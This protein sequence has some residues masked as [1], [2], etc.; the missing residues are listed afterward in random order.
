[1]NRSS[2][3]RAE[4]EA[5]LRL[6]GDHR[7]AG[8]SELPEHHERALA[9]QGKHLVEFRSDGEHPYQSVAGYLLGDTMLVDDLDSA[10]EMFQS[11]RIVA[12]VKMA[13]ADLTQSHGLVHAI[14]AGAKMVEE[15]LED[16]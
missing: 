13:Q 7:R 6:V 15:L 8:R 5:Q 11:E 4:G 12:V 2:E 10:L 16:G 1:M 3:Q 9:G 14:A